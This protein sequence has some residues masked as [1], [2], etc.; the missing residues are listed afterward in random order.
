MDL[1]FIQR[2]SAREKEHYARMMPAYLHAARCC[3]NSSGRMTQGVLRASIYNVMLQLTLSE[4]R[5]VVRDIR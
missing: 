4:M 2:R 1:V 3:C 5:H